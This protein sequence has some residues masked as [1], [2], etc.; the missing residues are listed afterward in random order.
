MKILLHDCC[1]PCGAFVVDELTRL[2]NEVAVYFYN[3]N[4]FPEDEYKLRLSEMERFCQKRGIPLFVGKYA[5]NEWREFVRGL[6]NKHYDSAL[7][8]LLKSPLACFSLRKILAVSDGYGSNFPRCETAPAAI[9]PASLVRFHKVCSMENE[10]EGGERCRKCFSH[11][12][13][14][15][16]QKAFEEKFGGFATTLTVSPCKPVETIN[17]IGRELAEF[18]GLKF[19]DTIWRKADGYKKAC[20]ISAQEHFHRQSY[21][22]CEFSIRPS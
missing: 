22:G 15:T 11:R 19:I 17:K 8:D 20:E 3:P 5:H 21:C 1:A 14:E 2:G 7:Y 12:L 16:A 4:I 6:W 10:P 18:Y 9:F 13:N